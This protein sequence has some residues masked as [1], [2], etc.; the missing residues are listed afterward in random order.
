VLTPDE[1]TPEL[2]ATLASEAERGLDPTRR[3]AMRRE[4]AR[5][6]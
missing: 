4:L 6:P 1:L 3:V 2:R 5:V